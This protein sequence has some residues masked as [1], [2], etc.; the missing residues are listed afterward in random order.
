MSGATSPSLSQDERR[1]P[2]PREVGASRPLSRLNLMT[3][4]RH[5]TGAYDGH[6]TEWMLGAED[7]NL[8]KPSTER[9]PSWK[10]AADRN[11]QD[12]TLETTAID[13]ESST[14]ARIFT[15][16]PHYSLAHVGGNKGIRGEDPV[17]WV[18][19]AVTFVR[20]PCCLPRVSAVRI[21]AGDSPPRIACLHRMPKPNYVG[22]RVIKRLV[23]RSI[24]RSTA[25]REQQTSTPHHHHPLSPLRH[26]RQLG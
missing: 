3:D 15:G 16:S 22:Q 24:I 19:A 18:A 14:F 2:V 23:H 26:R 20:H 10:R 5:P 6:D 1:K 21:L 12:S 4:V 25:H 7:R 9:V 11:E 13:P 8:G 17:W